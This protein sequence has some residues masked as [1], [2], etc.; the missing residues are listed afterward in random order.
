MNISKIDFIYTG[1]FGLLL[2][3]VVYASLDNQTKANQIANLTANLSKYMATRDFVYDYK[4]Y[5]EICNQF[6]L[7]KQTELA[8]QCTSQGLDFQNYYISYPANDYM[9]V[10]MKDGKS[11]IMRF[12]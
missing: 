4:E 5:S 7:S 3:L 1:M 12:R 10:C 11:Q 6:Q 8:K 2:I 9:I